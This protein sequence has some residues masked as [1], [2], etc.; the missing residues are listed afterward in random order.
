MNGYESKAILKPST[1]V[2]P[3]CTCQ[4]EFSKQMTIANHVA[5]RGKKIKYEEKH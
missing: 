3:C 2:D 4:K 5:M 1:E